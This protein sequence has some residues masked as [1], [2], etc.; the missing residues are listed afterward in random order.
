M[1][2]KILL[3]EC[4]LTSIL[5]KFM[6]VPTEFFYVGFYS[7]H[8]CRPLPWHIIWYFL[9]EKHFNFICNVVTVMISKFIYVCLYSSFLWFLILSFILLLIC[10]V[11]F[12]IIIIV[13][14]I[15]VPFVQIA[16]WS[17]RRDLWFKNQNQLFSC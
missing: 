16:R 10:I 1:L 3:Q 17:H 6:R 7:G 11:L 4:W 8:M 12:I 9:C 5:P 15:T 14:I 2:L 13:I